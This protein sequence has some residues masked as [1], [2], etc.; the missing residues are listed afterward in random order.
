MVGCHFLTAEWVACAQ[1]RSARLDSLGWEDPVRLH[2]HPDHSI[3]V[4]GLVP[5]QG[6]S[7]LC[8]R[9]GCL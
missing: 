5:R 7:G 4:L 9:V 8:G 2:P 3:Q 6:A 1:S